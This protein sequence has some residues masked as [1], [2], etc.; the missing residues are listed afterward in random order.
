MDERSL[1]TKRLFHSL[2]FP[3]SLNY[4]RALA[5]MLVYS[6]QH[7]FSSLS[8]RTSLYEGYFA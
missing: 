4:C 2:H 6:L 5:N 3:A 8:V 1:F 7:R